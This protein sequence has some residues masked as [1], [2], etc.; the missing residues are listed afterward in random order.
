MNFSFYQSYTYPIQA[1]SSTLKMTYYVDQYTAQNLRYSNRRK[2][3]FD[4]E[5]EIFAMEELSKK[6]EQ[7]KNE[8]L[9]YVNA[10][11]KNKDDMKI[12]D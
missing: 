2:L 1:V 5:V 6:C 12:Y 8:R 9:N 10:A 3:S 11:K 4:R 7:V